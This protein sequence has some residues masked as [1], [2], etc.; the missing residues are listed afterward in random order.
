MIFVSC[1]DLSQVP[2]VLVNFKF[3]FLLLVFLLLSVMNTFVCTTCDKQNSSL[4]CFYSKCANFFSFF[5]PR[6]FLF[7]PGIFYLIKIT[8]G[9]RA[10]EIGISITKAESAWKDRKNAPRTPPGTEIGI[11]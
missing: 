9:L 1:S 4:S 2:F 6:L 5:W 3:L 8:I 10:K 11:R 7:L